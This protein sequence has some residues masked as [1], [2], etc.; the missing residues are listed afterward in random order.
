VT[1][2]LW[3][4]AYVDQLRLLAVD[5]PDS[6]EVMVDERFPPTS[7]SRE[8]RLF[9]T[10]HR[11]APTGAVDGEGANVLDDLRDHDYRYVSNLVPLE[12]QGLTEPHV[13]ILDLDR[14]AGRPGSLLVLRGWIFTSDDRFI[15]DISKQYAQ[16]A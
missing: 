4:T 12:Y 13:V 10:V 8:L 1:E 16:R 7:G 15:V 14:N 9:Q 5:H 6:V 2:E 3:E 11:R